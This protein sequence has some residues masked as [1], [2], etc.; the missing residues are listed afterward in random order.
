V[1]IRCGEASAEDFPWC[2]TPG[3]SVS[4][5]ADTIARD[6]GFFMLFFA[7]ATVVGVVELLFSLKIVL[8]LLLIAAY[9]LYVRRTLHSGEALEEVPDR[10]TLWRFRSR[11]PSWAVVGQGLL[12]LLLMIV[13]AEIFVSAVEHGAEVASLPAGLVALVLAPLATELPEKL[14]SVIWIRDGKDTLALG[15]V[16]GAM[17]FQSTVPVT[18]GVLFTRWELGPMNVFSVVLALLSGSFV[19]VMLRRAGTLQAWHLM[20]GGLFYLAFLIGAIFAVA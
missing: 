17:V 12:S 19:H 2:K 15:N 20:V 13:G 7:V 18:F 4:I 6:I 11:P 5:D 16:T 9:A 10:L 3:K 14:N 8:A 1:E